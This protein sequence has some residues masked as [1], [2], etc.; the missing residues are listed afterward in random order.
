MVVANLLQIDFRK[1]RFRRLPL[2]AHALK[3]G[4]PA[5]AAAFEVANQWIARLRTVYRAP[6]MVPLDPMASFWRLDYMHDDGTPLR[7]R[8]PYL[9]RRWGGPVSWKIL[10]AYP[11]AWATA[12]GLG[13]RYRPPLWQSLILDAIRLLPG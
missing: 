1:S 4:D 10:A 7:R 3:D 11:E 13:A 12:A 5:P 2:P 9:R 6:Q 8:R